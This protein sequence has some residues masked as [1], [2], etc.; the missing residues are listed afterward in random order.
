M[1]LFKTS[2]GIILEREEKNYLLQDDWDELINRDG[3]FRFLSERA[4][5]EKQIDADLRD[6]LIDNFL[7]APIGSQE[8]WAA[9]VT[10]LRSR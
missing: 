8:V 4:K 6:M 2:K 7:Q 5:N 10:Y 3:L 1:K 9:G